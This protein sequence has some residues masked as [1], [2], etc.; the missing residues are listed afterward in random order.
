MIC[1]ACGSASNKPNAKFCREC[2]HELPQPTEVV[3]ACPRCGTGN[4]PG[5]KFC[6]SCGA[7]LQAISDTTVAST[8]LTI[9]TLEPCPACGKPNPTGRRFCKHCGSE[10]RAPSEKVADDASTADNLPDNPAPSQ[11]PKTSQPSA[12]LLEPTLETHRAKPEELA[13][14]ET[15]QIK[16]AAEIQKVALPPLPD[17]SAIGHP[18]SSGELKKPVNL[19]MVALLAGVVLL[20]G[21]SVVYMWW[22]QPRPQTPT[23]VALQSSAVDAASTPPPDKATPLHRPIETETLA[24]PTPTVAEPTVAPLI[25]TSPRPLPVAQDRGSA[26]TQSE[27]QMTTG[28]GTTATRR[29]EPEITQVPM[30]PPAQRQ[31]SKLAEVSISTGVPELIA[32]EC[33]SLDLP[34]FSGRISA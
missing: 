20:T 29:A 1:P 16:Q 28:Q 6:R 2:G 5:S 9:E 24:S 15:V 22:Q 32:H 21:S 19:W 27:A 30:T 33:A 31:D 26:H 11:V 7:V 18:D 23:G 34:P 14:V 8:P 4:K 17:A 3:P 12:P 13:R 25:D 10:M